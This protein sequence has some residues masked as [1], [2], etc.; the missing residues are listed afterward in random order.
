MSSVGI[1]AH[2]AM[3]EGKIYDMPDFHKEECR[4]Q[5]ENNHLT[6]FYGADGSEPTLPCCSVTDYKPTEKQLALYDKRFEK[7]S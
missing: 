1:L 4:K 2:R 6:P 3:L 7:N 5:Y